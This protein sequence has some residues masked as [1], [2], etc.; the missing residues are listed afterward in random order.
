M[1][2]RQTFITHTITMVAVIVSAVVLGI[3]HVIDGGTVVAMIAGVSG[4]TLGAVVS[5]GGSNVITQSQQV[6]KVTTTTTTVAPVAAPIAVP[7]SPVTVT[8]VVAPVAP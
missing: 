5:A 8:D 1:T 2:P 4:I 3:D 6:P 7:A